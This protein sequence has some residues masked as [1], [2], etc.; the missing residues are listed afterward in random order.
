MATTSEAIL[1]SRKQ[2]ALLL[3]IS[4]RSLDYLIAQGRL[5]TRRIGKRVL[6]LRQEVDRFSRGDHPEPIVPEARDGN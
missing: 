3:G 2:A 5:R 6:I 1:L 4:L